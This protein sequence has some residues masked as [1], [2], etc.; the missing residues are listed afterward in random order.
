MYHYLVIK[1]GIGGLSI[2]FCY[3]SDHAGSLRAYNDYKFFEMLNVKCV[4]LGADSLDTLQQTHATW[5][6][7]KTIER[8]VIY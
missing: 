8:R 3:D 4:L 1:S 6:D 5:V 7:G 2:A